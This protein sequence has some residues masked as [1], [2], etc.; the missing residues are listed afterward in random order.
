MDPAH[1]I[2]VRRVLVEKTLAASLVIVSVDECTDSKDLHTTLV[3]AVFSD[4]CC[5]F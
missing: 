1:A 5:I 2:C 4:C 3:N